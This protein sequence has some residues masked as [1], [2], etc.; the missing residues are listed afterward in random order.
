MQSND[1]L[2]DELQLRVEFA[3]IYNCMYCVIMQKIS[4]VDSNEDSKFNYSILKHFQ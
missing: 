3:D 2:Y 1:G 4:L